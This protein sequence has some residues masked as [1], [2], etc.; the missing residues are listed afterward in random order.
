VA[1]DRAFTTFDD[2]WEDGKTGGEGVISV[3]QEDICVGTFCPFDLG[4]VDS[5]LYVRSVEV[6][7]CAFGEIIEGSR[8]TKNVPKDR[9]GGRYLIDVP[10][11]VN[12]HDFVVNGVEDIAVIGG[13]VIF[14]RTWE[15]D[16]ERTWRWEGE[17]FGHEVCV[18]ARIAHVL[19]GG[20][21][22]V[23]ERMETFPV[24]D[25]IH[26]WDLFLN[27][28]CRGRR[29]VDQGSFKI[30]ILLLVSIIRFMEGDEALP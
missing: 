12:V 6:D 15:F 21:E 26:G 14:V 1:D 7:R 5:F 17:I 3:V 28:I 20:S 10:A 13:L 8:E 23:V 24:G 16:R 9:T 4:S 2:T 18:S 11:W 27:S 22:S 29:V 19:K 25:K 30:M